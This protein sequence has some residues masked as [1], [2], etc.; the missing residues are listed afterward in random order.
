MGKRFFPDVDVSVSSAALPASWSYT[1]ADDM[2]VQAWE[3]ATT[4]RPSA[5][6]P[7][8]KKYGTLYGAVLH[9]SKYRPEILAAMGLLGSCLTIPTERLFYCLERLRSRLPHTHAEP[10]RNVFGPLA[11]CVQVAG[12]RRLELVRTTVHDGLG[13]PPSRGGDQHSVAPPTLHNYV[14]D[15]SRVGRPRRSRD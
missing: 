12:P 13:D 15:R 10:R 6:E 11:P 5:P 3:D 7:L 1:P 9:A 4:R 2:L 14:I 8:V